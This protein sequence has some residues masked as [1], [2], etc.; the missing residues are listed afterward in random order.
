[1]KKKHIDFLTIINNGLN[2]TDT[3]VNCK[4]E[5]LEFE[6]KTHICI[7]FVYKGAKNASLEI[8]QAWNNHM[9]VSTMRNQQN[10]QI[11]DMV[12]RK[13]SEA[14]IKCA[15]LKG[16]SVSICY[17]EP[18]LRTL[19]DVDILVNPSD[20]DKAIEVLCGDEY[21]DESYEGHTFHYKYTLH[22]IPIEIH[23]QVTEYTSAEYGQIIETK[24]SGALDRVI[25]KSIDEFEFPCLSNEYQAATLLLHTQR[26]FFEN[27]LP[28]KMLCDWAM[29]IRTVS[30]EEW[31]SK[32]LPFIREIGLLEFCDAMVATAN[33]YLSAECEDKV[34]KKVSK[35][36]TEFIMLE[37]LN[38]GVIADEN[39][40]SQNIASSCSQKIDEKSGRILSL[41]MLIND[42]ARN[43]FRLARTSSV[44][45]PLFWIYIPLRYLARFIS[46]E[47]TG[48]SLSAFN[49]TVERKGYIIKEL[50][51]KD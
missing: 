44:F 32:V 34:T 42:I 45:L 47:R 48:I 33:E 46:G 26:H 41:F 17:N 35:K 16:S 6:A 1:M 14:D 12:L 31:K 9:I 29:F 4:I 51:L 7:P 8:P 22:G 49:E 23:K 50:K 27:R 2:N 19:G 10:L 36:M 28:I 39:S 37:F 5:D 18:M 3:A 43:E 40:L 20:Y 38:N 21:A 25:H 30:V 24:M 15:V 11:Q 13:L